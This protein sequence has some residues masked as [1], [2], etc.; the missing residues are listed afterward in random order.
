VDLVEIGHRA[1]SVGDVAEF[2][3]WRDVAV[4]RI[5]RL[6]A[7]ELGPGG[8]HT[9]EAARQVLGVIMAEDVLL[10]AAVANAGDHRGVIGGV[11][12]H[13]MPGNSRA[14]VDT[15]ASLAT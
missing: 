3:H 10:G 8:R 13:A 11:G 6:E 15:A 12:E 5:D 1:V 9:V 7:D 2:A 4:H 14:R